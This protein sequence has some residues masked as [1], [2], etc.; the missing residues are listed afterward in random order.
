[1]A[2][3]AW[4]VL[5]KSHGYNNSEAVAAKT[6]LSSGHV[7]LI[8]SGKRAPRIR[9]VQ[10]LLKALGCTLDELALAIRSEADDEQAHRDEARHVG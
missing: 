2:R 4:E 1:M 5:I 9:T 3:A 7:S 10:V 8:A 6:G